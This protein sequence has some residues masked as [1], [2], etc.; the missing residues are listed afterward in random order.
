MS[1]LEKLTPKSIILNAISDKLTEA[2][3]KKLTVIFNVLTDKYNVLVSQD[4]DKPINLDI[5]P[6]EMN[7]LKR[8]FVSKIQK[9]FESENSKD[10]KCIII[11][12]NLIVDT[13]QLK[14][15]IQDTKDKVTKFNY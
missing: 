8:V 4:L 15:F 11:E 9:K 12:V 6:K 1:L 5:E 2:G 13:E 7:L 14:I 10:V 3:I